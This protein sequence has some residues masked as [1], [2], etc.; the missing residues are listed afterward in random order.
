VCDPC[1][2][3]AYEVNG[4]AVSDFYTPRFFDPIEAPRVRYGFA[5]AL[6]APR[7]VLK[8]GYLT[9][10]DPVVRKWWHRA[11]FDGDAH[12][13]DADPDIVR[14]NIRATIDRHFRPLRGGTKKNLGEVPSGHYHDQPGAA[15]STGHRTCVERSTL[16]PDCFADGAPMSEA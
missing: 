11:W 14:S 10:Y 7:Q 1:S 9:W 8:G 5:G 6:T 12:T 2:D 16:K 3:S 13:D 4:I 15:P